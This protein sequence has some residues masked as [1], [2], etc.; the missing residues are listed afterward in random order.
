L[1]LLKKIWEKKDKDLLSSL[2]NQGYNMRNNE[3]NCKG[4]EKK[5]REK[6]HKGKERNIPK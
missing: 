4:E 5:K 6:K 3:K 1:K 2:L